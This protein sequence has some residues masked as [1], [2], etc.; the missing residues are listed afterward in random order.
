M[1]LLPPPSNSALLLHSPAYVVL[2]VA[3]VRMGE[4]GRPGEEAGVLGWWGA[5]ER[6][7]VRKI[8][9][10]IKGVREKNERQRETE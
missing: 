3:G 7:R 9:R 5:S 8:E 1:R 4:L 10:Q 6:D 2:A